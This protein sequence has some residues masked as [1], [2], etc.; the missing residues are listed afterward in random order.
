MP[1]LVMD[2]LGLQLT[3]LKVSLNIGALVTIVRVLLPA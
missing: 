1:T 3:L 2:L